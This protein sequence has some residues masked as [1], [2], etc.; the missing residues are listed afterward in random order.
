[1]T[2]MLSSWDFAAFA[3]C[4][5]KGCSERASTM[6]SIRA[7]PWFMFGNGRRDARLRMEIPSDRVAAAPTIARAG[8]LMS[9]DPLQ[10]IAHNLK[11]VRR[12]VFV[13]GQGGLGDSQT[14]QIGQEAR[15]FF[16]ILRTA[17]LKR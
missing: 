17:E 5:G 11:A 3:T 7:P 9:G 15:G 12:A 8:V 6:A 1:M 2:S 13:Q 16:G 10:Q 4:D 14:A